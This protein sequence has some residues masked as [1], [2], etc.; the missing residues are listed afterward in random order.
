MN[1]HKL[2][3]RKSSKKFKSWTKKQM[4]IHLGDLQKKVLLESDS[5]KSDKLSSE[6]LDVAL[7]L[8]C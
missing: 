8:S 3:K 4:R 2:V 1:E 5:D 6:I 7:L